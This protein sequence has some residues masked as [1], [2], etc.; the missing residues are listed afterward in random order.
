[1]FTAVI[2]SDHIP[3]ASKIYPSYLSIILLKGNVVSCSIN[4]M[5]KRIVKVGER[6]FNLSCPVTFLECVS[7][8]FI[9]EAAKPF[10]HLC[11]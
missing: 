10:N 8:L 7:Y 6:L 9:T 1:V 2:P 3:N 5:N 4:A 11:V